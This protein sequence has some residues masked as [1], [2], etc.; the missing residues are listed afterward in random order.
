MDSSAKIMKATGVIH[1]IHGSIMGLLSIFLMIMAMSNTSIMGGLL[2]LALTGGISF[3]YIYIGYELFS[4]RKPD[5]MRNLLIASIILACI[6]IVASMFKGEM[7]G[8]LFI[9]EL[10]MSIIA[11]CNIDAYRK[12]KNKISRKNRDNETHDDNA[13]GGK[14]ATRK[15]GEEDE[16]F[17]DEL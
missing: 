12:Y 14:D 1:I 16:Y 4:L 7:A 17:D 2:L 6:E 5:K 11:I 15:S 8:V 9:I 13:N 3:L 10:V